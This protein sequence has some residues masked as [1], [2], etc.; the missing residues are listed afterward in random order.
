MKYK[1][2]DLFAGIGGFHLALSQNNMECVFASEID[3][4]ARKTYL[5]NHKI[6]PHSFNDDIRAI[7][8]NDI[9]D[10]D[11]L[12]AGFPCQPFSQA[13]HKRGFDDIAD[14]DRGTLFFSIL[15]I[16]H[17]KRPKAFILE[18]V[19]HLLKHDNGRT[20]NII[21]DHLTEAGYSVNYKII[22]ASEFGRP[23]LRPRIYIVGFDNNNVDTTKPFLFPKSI[24]LKMTMSD[25]W[26]SKCDREI[27]FTL[28]VGGKCSPI[29]DRRNWDGY[30]INGEVKRLKPKQGKRMMGLP[31]DF[32]FPVPEAQ[33]MKQ[34]GNSVCVDVVKHIGSEVRAYLDRNSKKS[35]VNNEISQEEVQLKYAIN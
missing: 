15:E 31:E 12:C 23:Q 29:D 13:G 22:K 34:L 6:P 30:W 26:E 18:N 7:S 33:A 8:P 24:P 20:F 10:H 28:R 14:S 21:H 16:L 3:E 32:I 11:I 27:G 4:A 1:F 35:M 2:I 5:A 25:V 9:P 19:R 17:A